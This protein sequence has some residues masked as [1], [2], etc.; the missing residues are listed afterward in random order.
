MSLLICFYYHDHFAIELYFRKRYRSCTLLYKLSF[1]KI[2]G[3]R[4]PTII[5]R[6]NNNGRVGFGMQLELL[7]CSILDH[8]FL[9]FWL[10]NNSKNTHLTHTRTLPSFLFFGNHFSW[11]LLSAFIYIFI[12][13]L[14]LGS[15]PSSVTPLVNPNEVGW[16]WLQ[17]KVF[18]L[19]NLRFKYPHEDYS[20]IIVL[21]PL[22]ITINLWW[23]N[24]KKRT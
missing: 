23:L 8:F 19:F 13:T 22:L 15:K 11:P 4:W 17:S 10:H 2:Y 6:S 16:L 5:Q 12:Y 18:Y 24:N 3:R 20:L 7:L 1:K 21:N 9:H 14:G